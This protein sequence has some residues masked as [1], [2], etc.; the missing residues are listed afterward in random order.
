METPSNPQTDNRSPGF[1]I[2]PLATMSADEVA[3]AMALAR[4]TER[5]LSE[6]SGIHPI[7]LHNILKHQAGIAPPAAERRLLC[8]YF[9]RIGSVAGGDP[10]EGVRGVFRLSGSL[11]D[12][13][14]NILNRQ[15]VWMRAR[16]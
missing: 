9:C 14:L 7:T 13:W 16:G 5:G 12:R 11:K 3:A 15:P 2:T 1:A 10:A 6:L 4:L 8:A